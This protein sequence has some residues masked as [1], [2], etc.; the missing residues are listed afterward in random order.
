MKMLLVVFAV[1]VV[2]FVAVLVGLY[3]AGRRGNGVTHQTSVEIAAPAERVWPWLVDAERVKQWVGGLKTI[4][5]LTPDKGLE[6]GAKDRLV[7]EVGG[8]QH[9]LFSEVTRVESGRV[10]EQ[11]LWQ[12]G[13]MAW[14]ELARF[15]IEP[16]GDQRVRFIVTANYTYTTTLGVIMEPIIRIAAARKLTED[17]ARLKTLVESAP[18]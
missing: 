8:Q 15:T 9:E 16:A 10:V 4:E 5:T 6:V 12:G 1:I 14:H 17:L 3:I 7:V 2:L 11:R 13:P 18:Q